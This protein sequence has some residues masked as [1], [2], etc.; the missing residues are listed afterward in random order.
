[1]VIIELRHKK[2]LS[3]VDKFLQEHKSFLDKYYA[4][5][6]FIASGPKIPRDG[7]IILSMA[8]KETILKI[9]A[10]DPF[11]RQEIS[12]Y[13]LIEFEVGR[14]SQAFKEILISHKV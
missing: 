8:N 2:P 13:N 9:I 10:E 11:Y 4:Q 5:G 3:E 1:M 7:G 6:L 12:D 14:H